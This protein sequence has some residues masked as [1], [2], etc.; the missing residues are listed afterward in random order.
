[1]AQTLGPRVPWL[2]DQWQAITSKTQEAVGSHIADPVVHLVEQIAGRLLMDLIHSAL[3]VAGPLAI[4]GTQFF[5]LLLMVGD[6]KSGPRAAVCALVAAMA[7]G[8]GVS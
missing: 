2:D 6:K 5:L 7:Y 3:H 8:G 1:M 4:I